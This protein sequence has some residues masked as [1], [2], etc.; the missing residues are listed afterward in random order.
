MSKKL[1]EYIFGQEQSRKRLRNTLHGRNIVTIVD[2]LPPHV[3]IDEVLRTIEV[4]YPSSLVSNIEAI[5]VGKFEILRKRELQ[6]LYYNGTIYVTNEQDNNDDLFDDLVHEFSHAVESIKGEEIYGDGEI[7]AEFKKKRIQLYDLL[8]TSGFEPDKALFLD[9]KFSPELDNFLY[10]VVGYDALQHLGAG[11]FV[12]SY[13][14]TSLREYWAKG[15]EEYLLKDRN[16][17]KQVSPALFYK[18]ELL[19]GH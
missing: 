10:R 4:V 19:F 3:S 9:T 11:V 12:S 14:A 13:S 8:E 2:P 6:G 16:Y 1:H 15:V 7:K 18:I 17:L 5:Y